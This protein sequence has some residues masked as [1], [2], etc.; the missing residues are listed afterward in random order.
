MLILLLL[1][2]VFSA[3]GEINLEKYSVEEPW[4]RSMP[5][6]SKMTAAY[7]TVTNNSDEAIRIIAAGAAEFSSATLHESVV[8]D[9]VASMVEIPV[10]TILPGES[11]S[12]EPGGKH[13]MLMGG[14]FEEIPKDCCALRL[15]IEDQQPLLFYAPLNRH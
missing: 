11:V 5:P 15:E 6:G 8:T 14:R 7:F 12:L 9:G 4:V 2:V 10:L 13:M 1:P 3:C